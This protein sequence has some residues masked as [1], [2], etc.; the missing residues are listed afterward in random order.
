MYYHTPL[1]YKLKIKNVKKVHSSDII[2]INLE[3]TE[4]TERLK[5]SNK[6]YLINQ[7]IKIFILRTKYVPSLVKIH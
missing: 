6:N 3:K 5:K 2:V 7:K 4:T 1:L